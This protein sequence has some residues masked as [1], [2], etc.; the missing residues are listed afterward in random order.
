M[1]I[2]ARIRIGDLCVCGLRSSQRAEKPLAE[3][4][5]LCERASERLRERGSRNRGRPYMFAREGRD[6][7]GRQSAEQHDLPEKTEVE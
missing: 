6:S 5:G 4:D 7:R 2:E 1:G 3:D